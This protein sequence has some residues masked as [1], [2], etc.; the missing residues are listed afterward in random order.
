MNML[1]VLASG[2]SLWV[3]YGALQKDFVIILANVTSLVLI[4]GLVCLKLLHTS[5]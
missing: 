4:G 2:L 3:A 1:W 5:S